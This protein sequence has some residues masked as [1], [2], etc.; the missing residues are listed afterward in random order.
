M[1][2]APTVLE[3]L[4]EVVPQRYL[5]R[6][7][8]DEVRTGESASIEDVFFEVFPDSNYA[9]HQ[10]GMR[11]GHLKLIYRLSENYFELYDLKSDPGERRNLYDEHAESKVLT[12]RLL[13]YV[14]HHL[15]ALARGKSGAKRPPGSPDPGARKK[16]KRR[17]KKTR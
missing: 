17:K 16:K 14:D 9:G 2:V 7:R 3:L 6:S 13:R 5:G 8:A 11:A 1:E 12:Q 15:Y 4:G 10:V